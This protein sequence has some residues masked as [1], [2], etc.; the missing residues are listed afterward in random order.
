[1]EFGNELRVEFNISGGD[2]QSAK[3][4][5]TRASI[6]VCP[7]RLSRLM[8]RGEISLAR[9]DSPRLKSEEEL[10]NPQNLQ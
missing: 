9:A 1:M 8:R 6:G 2:W 10:S 7:R 4:K 5:L 3:W